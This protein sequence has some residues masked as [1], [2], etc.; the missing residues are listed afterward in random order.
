M[1]FKFALVENGEIVKFPYTMDDLRSEYPNT[2]FPRKLSDELLESLGMVR[3]YEQDIPD[4][5]P[6]THTVVLN[7]TPFQ[8]DGVWKR[9]YQVIPLSAESLAAKEQEKLEFIRTERNRRLQDTDWMALTDN[10]LSPEWAEYRQALRDITD[11]PGFPDDVEWPTPPVDTNP[12][13]PSS[14]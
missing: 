8:E 2:S 12:S 5:N 11:Q 10:T 6:D 4:Y 14:E 7:E 9:G 13:K 3:V 1:R